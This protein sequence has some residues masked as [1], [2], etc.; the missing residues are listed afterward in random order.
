VHHRVSFGVDVDGWERRREQAL[1]T[2]AQRMADRVRSTGR[3]VTPG[4]DAQRAPSYT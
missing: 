2:L 1:V 4:A 3:S